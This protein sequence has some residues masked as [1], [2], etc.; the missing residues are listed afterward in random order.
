MPAAG[1]IEVIVVRCRFGVCWVGIGGCRR[2]NRRHWIEALTY[3]H[4]SLGREGPTKEA[5]TPTDRALAG[6]VPRG[7]LWPSG[8]RLEE[9]HHHTNRPLHSPYS[10]QPIPSPKTTPVYPPHRHLSAPSNPLQNICNLSP[11][12]LTRATIALDNTRL[13]HSLHINHH[14]SAIENAGSGPGLWRRWRRTSAGKRRP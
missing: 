13:R 8:E 6:A 4:G 12:Q 2:K 7:W 3:A 10:Y 5:G 14:G 9:Q 11:T 1:C